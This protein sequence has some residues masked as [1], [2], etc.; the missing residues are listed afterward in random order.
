[1]TQSKDIQIEEVILEL[2]R[3][4][5]ENILTKRAWQSRSLFAEG[6]ADGGQKFTYET[7]AS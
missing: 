5:R 1:M 4:Q 3:C 2:M 6:S 7:K